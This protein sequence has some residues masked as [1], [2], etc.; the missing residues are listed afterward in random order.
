MDMNLAGRLRN[1]HL[2][3][4]RPLL[5]LYEALFNSFHAIDDAGD[6]EREIEIVIHRGHAQASM[7]DKQGTVREDPVVGFTV[8]DSGIGFDDDNMKSFETADS[9]YKIDRG[10]KGIGRLM[11]LKGFDAVLV[12]SVF[13]PPRDRKRRTFTFKA[14]KGVSA[15][16]VEPARGAKRRTSVKLVGL[17]EEYQKTCP[18]SLDGIAH[19]IIEHSLVHFVRPDCPHVTL[20]DEDTNKTLDVNVLFHDEVSANTDERGFAIKGKDFSVRT[21]RLYQTRETKHRLHL[22]AQTREVTSESLGT[23][24]ADLQR[25][26]TDDEGSFV[27]AAYVSGEILDE[28]VNPERTEFALPKEPD[29]LM[30]NVVS[31][32]EIRQGAAQKVREHL[33]PLLSTIVTEKREQI[34]HYV[35]NKAP[36]YRFLLKHREDVVEQIPAGLTEAGLDAAL[37]KAQY[38]AETTLRQRAQ[39]ILNTESD[40]TLG[41]ENMR[42]FLDEENSLGAAKLAAYIGHRKLVIDLLAK[43]L[44]TDDDGKRPPEE[45]VHELIF[46]LRTTSDD[47]PL[48]QQNLWLIDERL[49]YHRYLA[50]DTRMDSMDAIESEDDERADIVIF[51]GPLAFVDTEAPYQSVVVIEFKKPM[52]KD[53]AQEKQNPIRQVIRYITKIKSGHVVD[54]T[55][56]H[57][58]IPN[59]T[60]F[61]CYIVC[62]ITPTVKALASEYDLDPTPDHL[63]FFG[64]RKQHGAYIEIISYQKLL[65]DSRKRNRIL[66]DKLNIL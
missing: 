43:Q 12:D 25:K 6:G 32:D 10:G 13:G 35:E 42:K 18:R 15:K 7:D 23:L 53:L 1:T 59:T 22:C 34:R 3:V 8:M 30:P 64:Y 24:I 40:L 37:H 21:F 49:S 60:P 20:H 4:S 48:E 47:V 9:D 50:S 41:D 11:W 36:E 19:N 26:L 29:G 45:A 38:E 27:V 46:P 52:R 63:G 44:G 5:P 62:D 56:K 33:A 61:Y 39:T 55:G 2:P 51:N 31:V 54:R 28:N 14:P 17:H 16:H 66:F 65:A 58:Q 57:V